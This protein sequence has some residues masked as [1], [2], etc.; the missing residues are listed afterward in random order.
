MPIDVDF[1]ILLA[2]RH[3]ARGVH[4][5]VVRQPCAEAVVR[6]SRVPQIIVGFRKLRVECLAATMQQAIYFDL[7]M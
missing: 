5:R 2:L 3:W 4:W 7:S 6:A 1:G